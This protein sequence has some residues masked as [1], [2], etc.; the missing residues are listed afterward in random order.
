M[1]QFPQDKYSRFKSSPKRDAVRESLRKLHSKKVKTISRGNG[2]EVR[3]GDE[4][5]TMRLK[6]RTGTFLSKTGFWKPC[7]L[8]G[9]GVAGYISAVHACTLMELARSGWVSQWQTTAQKWFDCL[10]FTFLKGSRRYQEMDRNDLLALFLL[11]TLT[12]TPTHTHTG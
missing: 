9:S 10:L 3:A 7:D 1:A 11:H 6:K 2:W 12:H 8:A 5:S 4:L